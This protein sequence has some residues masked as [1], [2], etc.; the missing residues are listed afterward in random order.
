MFFFNTCQ[1][2]QCSTVNYT[3]FKNVL[4]KNK[5]ISTQTQEYCYQPG[6]QNAHC[7]Y[8][9]RKIMFKCVGPFDRRDNI[10]AKL[11]T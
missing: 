6:I 9:T 11:C 5:H 4:H 7:K 1:S 2:L 8:Y 3:V 10:M